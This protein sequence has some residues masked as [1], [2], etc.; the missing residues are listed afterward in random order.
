MQEILS[1]MRTATFEAALSHPLELHGFIQAG[2]PVNV[3]AHIAAGLGLRVDEFAALCGMSRATFHRKK[4]AKAKLGRLESDLVAR[5]AS[6]L[7]HATTVF[8]DAEA[9][10][11][12]LREKQIGLGGAVPI[13][14][15]QTTQGYQEVEK[16]LTRI[17][18]SVYA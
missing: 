4:T 17:D 6:L 2:L 8:A 3:V 12:W 7:K 5:Y 11:N 18:Y 1:Q 10:G 15:A 13:E 9:A 16:L 14:L